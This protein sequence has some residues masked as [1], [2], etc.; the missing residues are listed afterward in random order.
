[1]TIPSPTD[2][3]RSIRQALAAKFDNDIHRIGEDIR[4]QQRES[5]RTYISLPKRTP[6]TNRTTNDPLPPI[7]EAR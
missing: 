7:A 5:G 4:R 6:R 3:I 2:E 1:M